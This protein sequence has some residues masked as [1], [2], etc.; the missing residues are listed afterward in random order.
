MRNIVI[1]IF[2]VLTF[3]CSPA[4]SE[5]A[6]DWFNKAIALSDGKKFTDPHK[7]ILYLSNAIKIQPNDAEMYYNRGVAYENLG[8]YQPA[9]KDYNQAISLKPA[10]SEAFYNRGTLYSEI[11]QYRQAIEDFNQAISLQP[12]D[13][14]AYHGRGFAYD[15]L[16]QYQQ[17]IED[18]NKAISLQP[19]YASAYNNRGIY[20]LSHGNKTLG[21]FD[22][23]R[24]CALGNCKLLEIAKN[25][26]FCP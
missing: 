12:N 11:G 18:Y 16:G 2:L 6:A 23:Q 4:M 15:K 25:N 21:C 3:L 8:Q 5:T 26:G 7:A 19:N 22:A 9:I 24:A 17:A 20:F 1:S 14:E 10:Y 13:A